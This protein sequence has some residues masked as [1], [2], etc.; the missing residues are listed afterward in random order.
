MKVK[1]YTPMVALRQRA[2][3]AVSEEAAKLL[4]ETLK[5]QGEEIPLETIKRDLWEFMVLGSRVD[6]ED[7]EADFETVKAADNA[8]AVAIKYVGYLASEQSNLIMDAWT[9]IF[10][11]DADVP[12]DPATS[13]TPPKADD[14]PKSSGA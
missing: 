9:A 6:F 10:T 8:E 13:P 4:H 7:G 11:L 12:K 3:G 1:K 5:A 2:L 14:A